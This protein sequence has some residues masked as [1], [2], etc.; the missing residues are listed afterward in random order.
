VISNRVMRR[1][2]MAG[3]IVLTW[4]GAA[5]AQA[6]IVPA[7]FVD[8]S[9][10]KMP[11]LAVSGGD[12]LLSV[13]VSA[14]GAVSTIDVL[15]TTPPFTDVL[16]EAVRTWRF[17]PA[18]DSKRTP[19]DSRVL[20]DARIGSPGLS[21][22]TLGTPPKDVSTADTRVPFPAQTAPALY[23]PNA[24]DAGNVLVETRVDSTGHVVA[25]TAVRSSP[26]FDSSA[27]DAARAWTFR[28]V[29][30]ADAPPS[31]YAYVLF[32]F[33][34]AMFSAGPKKP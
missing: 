27:L 10:P 17:V 23:P 18:L 11:A 28:P 8:G 29:Q 24:R 2:F 22:P 34:Q 16:V 1:F 25:V 21:G 33:R 3:A 13:A 6:D 19:M 26:A 30:G 7:R 20:V 4:A 5:Q 31:T 32:V 12:V 9:I 15:R 14:S